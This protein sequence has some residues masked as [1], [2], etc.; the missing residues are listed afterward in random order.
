MPSVAKRLSVV[1]GLGLGGALLLLSSCDR[2]SGGEPSTPPPVNEAEAAAELP[3]TTGKSSVEWTWPKRDPLGWTF[4][5]ANQK[6]SWPDGGGIG[7]R[8]P[9]DV[10]HPDVHMRSPIISIS[11]S[12]Y[13]VV[14]VDLECVENCVDEPEQL[15]L[16]LYYTTQDR[17]E[18][19]RFSGTPENKSPITA[20]ERRRLK[21][22]MT[23]LARGGTDWMDSAITQIR[24]DIP[25][26]RDAFYI[27]HS[28][29][30]CAKSD[31][32]C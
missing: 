17:K 32:S 6:L 9:A 14:V 23:N 20:G 5:R 21:Y 15:D 3:S 18:T 8:T 30:I 16:T 10:D 12:D 26:G 19:I 28:I 22:D 1:T 11:G 2:L 25:Q 4:S 29:K 31:T 13:P 7:L 27:V 24:F